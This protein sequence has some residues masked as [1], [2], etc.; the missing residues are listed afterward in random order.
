MKSDDI[1]HALWIGDSL[2][3]SA[4]GCLASFVR[5][6]H[7]VQLYV[8]DELRGI[9]KGVEVLDANKVV[10]YD[11]IFRHPRTG[12]LATFANHFRYTLLHRQGGTWIDCDLYCLRPI[13]ADEEILLGY[14]SPDVINNALLRLPKGSQVTNDLLGI[15]E[16]RQSFLPWLLPSARR[17]AWFR[18]H[19]MRR[20]YYQVAT[21]GTTGPGALTWIMR[22]RGLAHLAKPPDVFYPFKYAD[23]ERAA[24]ADYDE[25]SFIVPE[26]M[27]FHLWNEVLR[28]RK[29]PPEPGSLMARIQDEGR[30]GLPAV[31]LD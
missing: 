23:A 24:D 16:H 3:A 19:F 31:V 9:P 4:A 14:E 1:Y 6:G 25:R 8:Y 7:R 26:S 15:F 28:H 22:E 13:P 11:R 10:S 12:S 2:P 30:G 5:H 18:H 17:R 27:T 21:F 20:P 29:G